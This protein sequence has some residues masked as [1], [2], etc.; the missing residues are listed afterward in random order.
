MSG[1]NIS[2]FCD[3]VISKKKHMVKFTLS[4]D[5]K[6]RDS[7]MTTDEFTDY[8]DSNLIIKKEK[9]PD[10]ND[11]FLAGIE[12]KYSI[13]HD[14]PKI[15]ETILQSQHQLM[16][17]HYRHTGIGSVMDNSKKIIKKSKVI[18]RRTHGKLYKETSNPKQPR[19]N[20][21]TTGKNQ[22]CNIQ[23][24]KVLIKCDE[25][26]TSESES[27]ENYNFMLEKFREKDLIKLI[28]AHRQMYTRKNFRFRRDNGQIV[29]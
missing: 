21:K 24:N 4:A 6:S 15:P 18:I 19:N 10:L 8:E 28:S 25:N 22:L 1:K 14:N 2:K 29:L 20:I 27:I 12:K 13:E 7:I 5:P 17:F 16:T 9:Y 3:L 11:S 23:R 26:E